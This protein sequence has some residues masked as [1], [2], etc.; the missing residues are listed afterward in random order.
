M[1]VEAFGV[2]YKT[3]NLVNEKIYIGQTVKKARC[4]LGSGKILKQAINKY[5]KDNFKRETICFCSN[6]KE[7]NKKEI[8]WIA[9]YRDIHINNM[10]NI[11]DGGNSVSGYTMSEEQNKKNSERKKGK[12]KGKDN[13]NYGKHHS[14]ES[15]KKISEGNKGRKHTEEQ[16]KKH[17]D[18]MRRR[19]FKLNAIRWGIKWE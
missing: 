8:Y 16:N 3:T 10:Y 2:V 13:P 15:K 5:G 17:S 4:Y 6:R 9:Y 18:L 7:L 11:T 1:A 14:E 12:M 19:S